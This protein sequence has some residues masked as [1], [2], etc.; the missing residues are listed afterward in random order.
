MQVAF[1]NQVPRKAIDAVRSH[2]FEVVLHA[3]DQS[4]R[5]WFED[6]MHMG[7]EVYVSADWDI[8]FLCNKYNKK[9]IRVPQGLGGGRLV[10]YVVDQLNKIRKSV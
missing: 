5:E 9:F 8:D 4:D 6:A 7:A 10:G 2:G 3:K 1:D